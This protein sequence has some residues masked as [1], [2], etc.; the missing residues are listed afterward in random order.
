MNFESYLELI[1][2]DQ[3][4][5]INGLFISW[6]EPEYTPIDSWESPENSLDMDLLEPAIVAILAEL[7][8]LEVDSNIF[9]GI[10][11]VNI[12]SGF[13]ARLIRLDPIQNG[14]EFKLTFE[15]NG[16]FPDAYSLANTILKLGKRL[17][18]KRWC[19]IYYNTSTIAYILD[20]ELQKDVTIESIRH[21]GIRMSSIN[22]AIDIRVIV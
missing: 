10:L 14:T 5:L 1:I 17:P 22:F 6:E 9:R 4:D 18:L 21:N 15:C 20:L 12:S 7:M 8:E 19:K 3:T 2:P 11:P 13:A 16:R